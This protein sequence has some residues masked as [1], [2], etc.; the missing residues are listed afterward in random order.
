MEIRFPRAKMRDKSTCVITPSGRELASIAT[1]GIGLHFQMKGQF[2]GYSITL[3][4]CVD[5]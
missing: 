1:L 4:G 2:L 3:Q 5:Q